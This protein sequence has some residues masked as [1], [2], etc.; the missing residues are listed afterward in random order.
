[1]PDE[2][3]DAE[4][5]APRAE[6]GRFPRLK[7]ARERGLVVAAMD[8]PYWIEREDGAWVLFVEEN[9]RGQA[10][11]AL[12]EFEAE[13]QARVHVQ[14]PEPLVIPKLALALTLVAMVIFY[15][16]QTGANPVLI[17]RGVA[18]D[19]RILHGEWWRCFTALTLH[20]GV[21]HL[22]SNLGLAVFAFAFAFSR[23][24]AGAGLLG[25]VLGGAMG[26]LLNAFAH[27]AKPHASLGSS[28][29]LFASLG[30]LAGGEL[31]ARLMHRATRTGWQLLVPVGAGLAFL[32]LYGG[33]GSNRD[34]TPIMDTGNVDLMAHLFGLVAGV[35][36]GSVLF[37]AGLRRGARAW[38]Q[39]VCGGAVIVVLA[40]A[41]MA[42]SRM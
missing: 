21:E 20:G 16:M 41:W 27:A 4:A 13:E 31:A 11:A 10:A 24:G 1:M 8:L 19:A 28:T 25:T 14:K 6:V 29:A 33:A 22:V 42:A 37:A 40:A 26:N 34:G 17:E 5:S 32:S 23:F 15:R 3:D 7:A 36:L 39:A 9:A 35:A 18:V 38:V 30:L 12:A 2:H